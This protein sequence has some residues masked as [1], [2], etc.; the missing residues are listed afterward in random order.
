MKDA[1]KRPIAPFERMQVPV[2]L[3]GQDG[4][5][6]APRDQCLLSAD[7]DYAAVKVWLD[8][9]N[10]PRRARTWVSYRREAERFLLWCMLVAKKP[11][12]SVAHE[13]AQ[14]YMLFLA[15]PQ[16]SL[17]WCGTRN[18]E[19]WSEEW[20][21]FE[22]PLSHA[23][24][25]HSIQILHKLYAFLMEKAYLI[26]NPFA[27]V[28]PPRAVGAEVRFRRRALTSEEWDFVRSR[29]DTQTRAGRRLL[30]I[31]HLL[32]ATGVRRAN[33]AAA[34]WSDLELLEFDSDTRA[35]ML[36]MQTKGSRHHEVPVPQGVVEDLIRHAQ[37]RGLE[38]AQPAA[39]GDAALI[40]RV[41]DPGK[42]NQPPANPHATLQDYRVA[43][44][45]KDHFAKCAAATDDPRMARKLRQ[46][47]THWMRHTHATHSL[48]DGA[49]LQIVRDNLGHASISTTSIYVATEQRDRVAAME[50]FWKGRQGG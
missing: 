23:S 17:Q 13:D 37:D 7:E 46:A 20:R 29:I 44:L 38:G 41:S 25:R 32:Y 4:R 40:G 5:F 8:S 27:G 45:V 6:R 26:G 43:E 28:T 14:A 33:L 2:Q 19:R 24:I 34:R 42:R 36:R 22:G 47:S 21:P 10:D 30:A 1:E 12:S 15:D 35:W 50:S 49:S 31:F 3:R 11:M 18:V 9:Y 16:P 39:W 48:N